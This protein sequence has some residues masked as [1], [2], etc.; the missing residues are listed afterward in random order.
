MECLG[1]GTCEEGP[2]K[3]THILRNPFE[4]SVCIEIDRA[5]RSA[6]CGHSGGVLT[7]N[8]H[9]NIPKLRWLTMVDHPNLDKKLIDILFYF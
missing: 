9:A 1:N 6:H 3:N 8:F 7:P 4:L 2:E 5:A